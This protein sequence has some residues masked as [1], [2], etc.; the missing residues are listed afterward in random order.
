M[1]F[2]KLAMEFYV[3]EFFSITC[4]SPYSDWK[5]VYFLFAP[6]GLKS[7]GL[8]RIS[9]FSESVEEVKSRFDKGVFYMFLY[10][11]QLT[12]YTLCLPMFMR[13][14]HN[15]FFIIKWHICERLVLLW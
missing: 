5:V 10:N 15:T 9:G 3:A 12:N 1:A 14:M 13:L 8:Y 11:F 2:P 7:E 6:Q 4:D